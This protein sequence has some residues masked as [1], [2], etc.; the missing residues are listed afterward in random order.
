LGY[1]LETLWLPLPLVS[2]QGMGSVKAIVVYEGEAEKRSI[3]GPCVEARLRGQWTRRRSVH[4][5]NYSNLLGVED[6]TPPRPRPG[7]AAIGM[8]LY[9]AL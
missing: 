1:S 3:E 2:R 8:E 6:V 9:R 4:V 7:E 5:V